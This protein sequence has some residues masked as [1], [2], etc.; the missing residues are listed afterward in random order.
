MNTKKYRIIRVDENGNNHPC[1]PPLDKN[2]AELSVAHW[3]NAIQ[4]IKYILEEVI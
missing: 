4:S 1:T 2:M 3:N